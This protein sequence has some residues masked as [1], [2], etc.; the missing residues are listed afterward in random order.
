MAHPSHGLRE[1]G[2]ILALAIAAWLLLALLSYD[3][4]DPGW[5]HTG[6]RSGIANLAGASGAWTADVLLSV[7]GWLAAVLPLAFLLL[8][9]RQFR[10]KSLS[11]IMDR[12]TASLRIT[13]F[14][15]TVAAGCLLADL[16]L[17]VGAGS[18]PGGPGG[19]LGHWLTDSTLG[20]A[21]LTGDTL[22]ALAVFLLGITLFTGLSW[23]ALVERIGQGALRL[24]TAVSDRI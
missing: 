14:A 17:E 4:A 20:P 10:L 16:H 5:S 13:G 9:V 19:I 18:L 6:S 11:P 1:A 21:G 8:A 24:V 22:L 2:L 15:L 12:F 3:P 7:F 23:I